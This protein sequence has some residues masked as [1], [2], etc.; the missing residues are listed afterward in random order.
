[1][2]LLSALVSAKG[3]KSPYR[4]SYTESPFSVIYSLAHLCSLDCF[5]LQN[6]ICFW[7]MLSGSQNLCRKYCQNW[8]RP[9][10]RPAQRKNCQIR[11]E[12][13]LQCNTEE[14]FHISSL[15]FRVKSQPWGSQ[16]LKYLQPSPSTSCQDL[17]PCT[18]T[19]DHCLPQRKGFLTNLFILLRG[20]SY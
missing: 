6:S 7:G 19:D 13:D 18:Y 9:L 5:T 2:L 16:R 12:R 14:G 20:W 17:S 15:S 1:M 10:P 11:A 8:L 3:G 4:A